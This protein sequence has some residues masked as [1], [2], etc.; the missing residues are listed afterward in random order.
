MKISTNP[1]QQSSCSVKTE[2][3]SLRGHSCT[4]RV[5]L[6]VCT[7]RTCT[8]TINSRG[9]PLPA[10]DSSVTPSNRRESSF[11]LFA[12]RL[13]FGEEVGGGSSSGG[14]LVWVTVSGFSVTF[15]MFIFQCVCTCEFATLEYSSTIYSVALTFLSDAKH[16]APTMVYSAGAD[17]AFFFP[18]RVG[19]HRS[20]NPAA[21][22]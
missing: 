1:T 12:R 3:L 5:L 17:G 2:I 9:S 19:T 21:S 11:I 16:S 10:I 18:L 4:T 6:V 15:R 8:L 13:S 7:D 14:R 22:A 20:M